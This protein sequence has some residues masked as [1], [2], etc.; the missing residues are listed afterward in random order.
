MTILSQ[1]PTGRAFA[2][3]AGAA[4]DAARAQLIT[5]DRTEPA[6]WPVHQRPAPRRLAR[7]ALTVGRATVALT[8]SRGRGALSFRL[9]LS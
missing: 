3:A 7:V 4:V 6:A 1:S 2:R 9:S 8:L 5:A